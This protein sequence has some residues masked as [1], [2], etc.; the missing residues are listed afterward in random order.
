MDSLQDL[1]NTFLPCNAPFPNSR[2]FPNAELY[3]EVLQ[4]SMTHF[5][6]L[7]LL[8]I[9][10]GNCLLPGLALKLKPVPLQLASLYNR[11]ISKYFF[12]T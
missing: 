1:N 12:T 4:L 6:L 8:S 3:A 11:K 9:Q 5:Q 7:D 10:L 2:S